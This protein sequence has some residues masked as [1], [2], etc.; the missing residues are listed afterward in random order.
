M[1]DQAG[2]YAAAWKAFYDQ[3][4][5]IQVPKSEAKESPPA[6]PPH[7]KPS[8]KKK[9]KQTKKKKKTQP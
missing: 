9:I 4:G 2:E 6:E 3:L 1:R 8:P 7:V 5:R